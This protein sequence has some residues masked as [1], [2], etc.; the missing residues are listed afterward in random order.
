[1]EGDGNLRSTPS[2]VVL[3]ISKTNVSGLSQVGGTLCKESIE[4]AKI[5]RIRSRAF[6]PNHGVFEAGCA[7]D[8]T[9]LNGQDADGMSSNRDEIDERMTLLRQK[10]LDAVGCEDDLDIAL[11]LAGGE[12]HRQ[13]ATHIGISHTSVRRRAARAYAILRSYSLDWFLGDEFP[14]PAGVLKVA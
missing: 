12:S 7:I 5:N 11:R 6:P 2:L 13:I 3:P 14:P 8:G 10:L 4:M 1:M 9:R